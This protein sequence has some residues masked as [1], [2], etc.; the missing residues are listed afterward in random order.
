MW[1]CKHTIFP[2]ILGVSAQALDDETLKKY[3]RLS[4]EQV[5]IDDKTLSRYEWSQEQRRVETAV[6]AVRAQKDVA[7]LAD[8]SGD[9]K[10]VRAAQANIDKLMDYYDKISEE[11]RIK[12]EYGRMA[13]STLIGRSAKAAPKANKG[14]SKL[15]FGATGNIINLT[16]DDKTIREYIRSADVPKQ[17]NVGSQNKHIRGSHGY[18]SNRSYIFGDIEAAQSLVDA[19]HGTGEIK[20]K[21]R[22]GEWANREVVTADHDIGVSIDPDTGVEQI[23]DR[24]TIH[25]GKKGT[26][27]VPTRRKTE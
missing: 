25:Y 11:S 27:V 10:A 20:R 17:I 13:R 15:T 6:R 16:D 3:H 2:I 24:F 26:H 7:T 1:N 14:T 9:M 5:T 18:I 23:T 21:A 12:H 19:Y 4:A 8:A 22:T